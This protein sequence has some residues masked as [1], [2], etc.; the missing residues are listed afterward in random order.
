MHSSIT[1]GAPYFDLETPSMFLQVGQLTEALVVLGHEADARL[2]QQRLG[3]LAAEQ[4]AAVQD[5]LASPP[6]ALAMPLSWQVRQALEAQ[7]AKQQGAGGAAAPGGAPAGSLASAVAAVLAAA[8]GPELQL[9]VAE[10]EA[11]AK[12]AHWKWDMLRTA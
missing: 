9:K 12:G 7:Q 4:Q 3:A 2:L 10:A 8:P 1:P 6:P 5:V 11:A